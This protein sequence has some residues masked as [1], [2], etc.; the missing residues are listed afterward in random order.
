MSGTS[1][2]GIDC[3]IIK[4]NGIKVYE[5][6]C[7]YYFK[8]PKKLKNDLKN[9]IK[10]QMEIR[11]QKIQKQLSKNI[12]D[13]YVEKIKS[14]KEINQVDLIGFHG[15]TI[16]HEPL[17]SISVQL[18][19]AQYLSDMTKKIVVSDFRSND[20]KQ[21]GQ[22]APIA[23]IYHKLII[24]NL[25]LKLPSCFINIGGVSN[26][27]YVDVDPLNLIGFDTGPGNCLIDFITKKIFKLEFDDCG[28]LSSKGKIDNNFLNYLLN[29]DYFKKT[30]PKSLD[31]Q[32]F[33]HYLENYDIKHIKPF[34]ILATLTEFTV[35]T[36]L[37][38]INLLPKSPKSIIY[39]GGGVQNLYLM[40]RIK[41][42][43]DIFS[44]DLNKN[45]YNSNFIESE[46]IAFL[47]ARSFYNMPITF[48][49]TTGVRKPL[50]GG[51]I[52]YP[53]KIH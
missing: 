17:K 49:K 42:N 4:T 51:E 47:S 26:L 15:Q 43:I 29:D 48:P 41:Q 34:D 25:N 5:R 9:Y 21:G 19:N 8:Y 28:K 13:F 23:P 44:V 35:K 53:T 27:T 1:L 3:S 37:N 33:N 39:S 10:I 11:N 38:S 32:H 36:I 52:F 18:G 31:N 7:E 12:T 2:D 14:I 46:L 50:T 16:Y 6:S 40:R 20:M 30:Y 22:G 24:E 45:K